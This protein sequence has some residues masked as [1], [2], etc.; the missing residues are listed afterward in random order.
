MVV[1]GA[2]GN[3]DEVGGCRRAYLLLALFG[4]VS[5]RPEIF[6]MM[7]HGIL[8]PAAFASG[9]SS[10]ASG[11]TRAGLLPGHLKDGL[12]V[13]LLLAQPGTQGIIHIV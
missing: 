11:L 3:A 12:H 8:G 2:V 6:I 4:V 1:V 13:L 9:A 10:D 7:L 5:L